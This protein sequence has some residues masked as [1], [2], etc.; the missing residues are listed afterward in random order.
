MKYIVIGLG[1]LGRAIA[2]DLTRIG[3]EVIGIDRDM[4]QVDLIKQEVA[5]AIALDSTDRIAL[6]SL[7]LSETDGIFVTFGKDFGTSVQTTALLKSLET[8]H[9]IVRAIS[10]IHE[11]VI[12]AIG[13]DEIITPEKDFSHFYTSQ[14]ALGE[15]FQQWYKV[16]ETEHLYKVK[17]PALLVGQN[18]GH[19]DF[20]EHFN[21]RLV[22]IER[23]TQR[24]NLLG[25]TQVVQQVIHSLPPELTIE[26]DDTLLLFGRIEAIE[27]LGKL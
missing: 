24:K 16:T 12:R 6:A 25:L 14:T 10:P 7:P 19:I 11:T 5:G 18:L 23:P 4:R 1:N 17:T 13:V 3:H 27:R 21:L 2:C 9:L 8:P 15:H 26:E 20:E 22:A